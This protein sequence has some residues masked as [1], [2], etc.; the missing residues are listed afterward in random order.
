MTDRF[1]LKDHLFNEERVSYLSGLL[2]KAIPEFNRADFESAVMKEMLDLE[3]K[4]RIAHIATVLQ[5]HLA[6]DFNEAADQIRRSLPPPLDPTLGDDDFGDFI[7]APFGKY[8]EDRGLDYYETSMGLLKEL[9]MRFSME[10]PIR[11]FISAQPERTLKLY[12]IWARDDNYH[13]RRLVSESTRPRLPWASRIDLPADAALPL[14]DALHADPTRYVTR[15]VANHLNDI[16]K[17]EP[18]LVYETIRRWQNAGRQHP[19]E[20]EWMIGHSL[21]TLVKQGDPEAMKL[22]G[23]APSPDVGCVI[24]E[25]T[26]EMRAGESLDF[27]VTI[28]ARSEE[29]LLVDYA[30]DFVKKSGTTSRKVYKLKRLTMDAGT[31]ETLEK[32]HVIRA[33]ASTYSVYPGTHRLTILVNGSPLAGESFEI[34]DA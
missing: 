1:S 23:Y 29:E 20:L 27:T 18:T 12:E 19:R 17:I 24:D 15:S 31:T 11:A 5:D 4:E 8:V 21:R 22:L 14:L 7:F 26:S 2:E 16:T 3:L 30:I 6:V 9:T 32:H 33:N 10:G 13:V 28:A 25:V 34:V